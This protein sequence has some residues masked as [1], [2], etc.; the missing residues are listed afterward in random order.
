[1]PVTSKEPSRRQRRKQRQQNAAEI[2]EMKMVEYLQ[3]KWNKKIKYS[4]AHC[5]NDA[6]QAEVNGVQGYVSDEELHEC[7]EGRLD[8][9]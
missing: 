7:S 2:E 9:K 4:C 1:M 8:W 6:Y 3:G 5:L